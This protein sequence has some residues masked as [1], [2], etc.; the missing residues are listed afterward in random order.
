MPEYL[1][2]VTIPNTSG[3]PDDSF[4]NTWS[5]S[6]TGLSEPDSAQVIG[7]GL[8]NFYDAVRGFYSAV[9]DLNNTF[10]QTY[11]LA[12]PEP[13]TPVAEGNLPIPS[14]GSGAVLPNEVAA[15][16]S[17][18]ALY[19]SGQSQARRRGRVYLGPLNEDAIDNSGSPSGPAISPS[20]VIAMQ[21][22]TAALQTGL[23]ANGSH[24]VYS[25]VDNV[26]RPVDK[27]FVQNDLDTQ[28]SRGPAPTL[29]TTWEQGT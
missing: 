16:M 19:V 26:C 24:C 10:L 5:F 6:T 12:D 9:A 14:A 21:T 1:S 25:R 4:V 28:R 7:Q 11:D 29:R 2:K 27:Y 8:L 15:C 3:I 20:F 23:T 18:H 22:G 13:R 17:F